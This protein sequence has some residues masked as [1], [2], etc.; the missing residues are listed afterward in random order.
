ME[1][2]TAEKPATPPPLS[3]E[4]STPT[5][6]ANTL[7]EDEDASATAR[8][9]APAEP[10]ASPKVNDASSTCGA[11]ENA[12]AKPL[13]TRGA[14][15]PGSGAVTTGT[16]ASALQSTPP[17]EESAM[18]EAKKTQPAK[19]SIVTRLTPSTALEPSVNHKDEGIK[20][21]IQS[22]QHDAQGTAARL[23]SKQEEN[24]QTERSE[25]TDISL[26]SSAA[27]VTTGSVVGSG[28]SSVTQK[29][30]QTKQNPEAQRAQEAATRLQAK[31][32]ENEAA[33]KESRAMEPAILS[34]TRNPPARLRKDPG[35]GLS[36]SM[37]L[38]KG[39][40]RVARVEASG[41]PN[42]PGR[43][44]EED[45]DDAQVKRSVIQRTRNADE[46]LR[47]MATNPAPAK[48][49][50]NV[51][52]SNATQHDISPP[53]EEQPQG[54][55]GKYIPETFN[56]VCSVPLVH[57]L[58]RTTCVFTE[59]ATRRG[60]VE[61]NEVRP[62]AYAVDLDTPLQDASF[63]FQA[64][65]EQGEQETLDEPE[66]QDDAEVA[67]VD[68]EIAPIKEEGGSPKKCLWFSIVA[69]VVVILTV[70]V[71]AV[72][73]AGT[74]DN[75]GDRLDT[76]APTEE[77]ATEVEPTNAP[78]PSPT[79]T[80][81]KECYATTIDLL[82]PLKARDLNEFADIQICRNSILQV[83]GF[84]TTGEEDAR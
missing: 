3:D 67:V 62:G 23:R 37:K 4:P 30:Q 16:I 15:E 49:A 51:R 82:V 78:S 9:P 33:D 54:R 18:R 14:L 8:P 27:V 58:T 64:V 68:A 76:L 56:R 36:N 59:T 45:F 61:N 47:A 42:P 21:A 70:V 19:G 43:D 60:V 74:G 28:D 11:E 38:A 20:R 83:G 77:S 40:S 29:D 46:E 66:A 32:K 80:P 72:V 39:E 12:P 22:Q 35:N 63:D 65:I 55:G 73:L 10:S 71:I 57:V 17:G 31:Q 1:K 26:E 5:D 48:R 81:E 13:T 44:G 25:P 84:V 6:D 52:S 24:A 41:S 7:M 2:K 79:S 34:V 75:D 53:D 50:W 69:V